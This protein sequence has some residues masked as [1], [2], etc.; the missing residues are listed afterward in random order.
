MP[1][2]IGI[3]FG[4]NCEEYHDWH[5]QLSAPSGNDYIRKNS[6]RT[7]FMKI[8]TEQYFCDWVRMNGLIL[9]TINSLEDKYICKTHELLDLFMKYQETKTNA[10]L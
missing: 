10:F 5:G 1:R 4:C 6:I 2:E 9:I 7:N 8:F 3:N